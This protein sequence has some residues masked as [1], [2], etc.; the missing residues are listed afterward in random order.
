MSKGVK[1]PV[2]LL[3]PTTCIV[4]AACLYNRYPVYKAYKDWKQAKVMYAMDLY[5]DIKGTYEG[6]YP[7]LNDNA[8]FLFEYG[9]T[10]SKTGDYIVS[11]KILRQGMGKSCDPMFYNISGQNYQ[12]LQNYTLAEQ[13][14]K[15]AACVVPHRIYPYYLLTKLY[16]E[17]GE[18]QKAMEMASIVLQKEP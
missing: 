15:K 18:E 9:R 10:L 14:F 13:Q 17:M 3:L 12:S 7:Y 1:I 5:A 8:E 16:I 11:N 2:G 6:L 4:V